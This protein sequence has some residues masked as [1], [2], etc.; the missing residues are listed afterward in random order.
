MR[1]AP[2]ALAILAACRVAPDG[3]DAIF[4]DGDGRRVH[5]VVN[6]DSSAGVSLDSVDR[7][8]DRAAERGEVVEL[9][10]H[11]PGVT[12]PLAKLEHVLAGAA[13]RGLSP[14]TYADF[15]AGRGTGPGLALSFDDAAI[16]EWTAARPIFLA[17]GARVS[18]FVTRYHRF[19]EEGRAQLRQLADD[20]HDIAAHGV[21][22]QHAPRYV[23]ERGLA[24]YLAEEALPSIEILRADGYEVTS[25]A[26]PF[27]ART[28]EL[29][30]AL[31]AHVPVLRSVG[32][33]VEGPFSPCPR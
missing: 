20:G 8:L 10:A 31:A 26:Y 7:A 30:R 14:V 1:L 32:F 11:R 15:A 16:A 29:D 2:C 4:Y 24:A 27:G 21:D 25:F 13:A 3:L 18:F 12:V 22:H 17:F 33:P 19:S 9:Y 23:E 6:L 28:D 5:C